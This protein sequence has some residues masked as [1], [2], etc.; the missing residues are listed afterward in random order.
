[1]KAT[2]LYQNFG[3]YTFVSEIPFLEVCPL[4]S[5]KL[6]GHFN[7]HIYCSTFCNQKNWVENLEEGKF[8]VHLHYVELCRSF[9]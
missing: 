1:M 9:T 8:M 4:H 6:G 5:N 3:L 7:R 2:V